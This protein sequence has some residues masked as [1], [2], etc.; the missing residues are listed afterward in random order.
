MNNK[1][2][3]LK[4]GINNL[5]DII[6]KRLQD[7][8]QRL[9]EKC[10]KLEEKVISIETDVNSLNQYGRRSKTVFTGIPSSVNDEDLEFT[11]TS[12]LIDIDVA[13]DTNDIEDCHC[14]GKI[15]S[16]SKSKK[17]IV[18][19][20]NKSYCEK[21]LLN[22]K[23][24]SNL[25]HKKYNL[26]RSTKIFINE[27]LTRMNES[28]AYE[29]RNLKRKGVTSACYTRNGVVHIKKQNIVKQKKLNALTICL[30]YFQI[31]LL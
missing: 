10:K 28:I 14:F 17:T 23:K 8:N 5:K 27:N 3:D 19:F 25:D 29:G 12:I 21:A 2:A 30:N 4:N 22:K 31:I 6:I 7:E 24:L 20:V 15:D 9:Q 13:V 11:V 1:F 16:E 26:S 18:R